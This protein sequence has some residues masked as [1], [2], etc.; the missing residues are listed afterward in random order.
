MSGTIRQTETTFSQQLDEMIAQAGQPRKVLAQELSVDQ[1]LISRWLSGQRRPGL[2]NL[3][4]LVTLFVVEK[5]VMAV[6]E[7]GNWARLVHPEITQELVDR[8]CEDGHRA[9]P[10]LPAELGH[11][12]WRPTFDEL[13]RRLLL[14]G[15]L[16]QP[17][18]GVVGM[19]GVGKSALLRAVVHDLAVLRRYERILYVGAGRD[20]TLPSI[21]ELVGVQLERSDLI[22]KEIHPTI[23]GLRRELGKEQTLVV[24]DDVWTPE[25]MEV[26]KLS[27]ARCRVL[28]ATRQEDLICVQQGG[29]ARIHL[30]PM[31]VQEGVR[32]L[33]RHLGPY[34]RDEMKPDAAR[35]V[36]LV[37]GLPLALVI[38]AAQVSIDGWDRW[39]GWLSDPGK[40]L[41]RL[42]LPGAPTR[43]RSVRHS[44][45]LSFG[46]L[47]KSHQEMLDIA[48]RFSNPISLDQIAAAL[49][50]DKATAYDRIKL[51]AWRHLVHMN[52]DQIRF[53][54]L[55]RDFALAVKTE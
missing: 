33:A 31:N 36:E 18:L 35:V 14:Q 13:R 4:S 6:V 34:W 23:A 45:A 12:V 26:Q 41:G 16:R 54:T 17:V 50:V 52:G 47:D 46:E 11:W 28:V 21:L 1:S 22:C 32:L 37:E 44:I 43:L 38:V 24:V 2:G 51:L 8:W 20:L 25:V 48:G 19:P 5:G 39:I 3:K 27:C 55:V 9:N 7:A 49:Q 30:E 40:R 10:G 53:H 29:W 15:K 42:K